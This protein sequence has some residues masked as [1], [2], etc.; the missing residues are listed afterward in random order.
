MDAKA[1]YPSVTKEMASKSIREGVRSTDLKW[2][3]DTKTLVR[4]ASLVLPEEVKD[5]DEMR[6]IL[7]RPKKKTTINSFLN[8]SKQAK[9][10]GGRNQFYPPARGMT[11]EEVKVV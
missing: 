11:Q 5:R 1:L 2:D 7:P 4:F 3:L 8:P 10:N 9:A 6:E